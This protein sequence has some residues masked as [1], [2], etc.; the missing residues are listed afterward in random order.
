LNQMRCMS[1]KGEGLMLE[2]FLILLVAA[3]SHST[4][5]FQ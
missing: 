1:T 4:E 5:E 3:F 2:Q